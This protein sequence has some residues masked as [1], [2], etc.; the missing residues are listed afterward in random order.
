[1]RVGRSGQAGRS[2][3]WLPSAFSLD[4]LGC[5]PAPSA[6][7]ET[8]SVSVVHTTAAWVI[9]PGTPVDL[10]RPYGQ[11][12]AE[13]RFGRGPSHLAAQPSIATTIPTEGP[14]SGSSSSRAWSRGVMSGSTRSA[15]A[16]SASPT[17]L[18]STGRRGFAGGIRTQSAASR[19]GGSEATFRAI[20]PARPARFGMAVQRVA[21]SSA[22]TWPI[23]PGSMATRAGELALGRSAAI[24]LVTPTGIA[25][26]IPPGLA[27]APT[28]RH[29]NRRSTGL[30]SW[31]AV[32]DPG[33]AELC[34]GSRLV[35]PT[36]S[37]L[38]SRRCARAPAWYR[39]IG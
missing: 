17:G 21:L 33:G 36:T 35:L 39:V 9:G 6:P 30:R 22:P 14:A 37:Q 34:I 2:G 32:D 3:S 1:M 38:R 10:G 25:V 20:S 28:T 5:E 15:P 19:A 27:R 11:D 26:G 16:G 13:P 24:A 4:S 18:C 12:C 23:G 29:G 7:L 8:E 31:V